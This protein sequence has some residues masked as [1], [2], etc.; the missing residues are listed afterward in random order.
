MSCRLPS[1]SVVSDNFLDQLIGHRLD[2]KRQ[3]RFAP[4]SAYWSSFI[5]ASSVFDLDQCFLLIM[6]VFYPVNRGAGILKGG[7]HP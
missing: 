1:R 4:S 5:S 6:S 7:H 2:E 3:G